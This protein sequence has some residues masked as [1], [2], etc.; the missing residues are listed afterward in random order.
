MLV[1]REAVRGDVPTV[2]RFIREL[3]EYEKL[4]HEVMAT[5]ALLETALFGEVARA[6]VVMAEWDGVA[7]GFALYFYNF[8]TFLGRPGIYV[9]DVYVT[10]ECR[11][12]GIGKALFGWLAAKAVREGCGRLEWWVLDWNESAI[13]FYRSIGAVGMEEWTVQRVEGNALK[14]LA[15]GC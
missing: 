10:P 3:A 1:L 2:L 11:G 12:K 5:E 9:E 7:V 4:L 8:S 15:E 13:R 14:E 6:Q